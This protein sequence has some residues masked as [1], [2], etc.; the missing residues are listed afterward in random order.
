[1]YL[2]LNIMIDEVVIICI[3]ILQVSKTAIDLVCH[4]LDSQLF[5]SEEL[6]SEFLS[7]LQKSL[8]IIQV[9]LEVFTVRPIQTNPPLDLKTCSV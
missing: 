1:M 4:L 3:N 7:S 6:W 8:P 2:T 5:M 9:G